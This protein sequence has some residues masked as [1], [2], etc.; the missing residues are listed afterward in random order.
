MKTITFQQML[1]GLKK[2]VAE[3][4]EDFVYPEE[5]KKPDETGMP[6]CQY[7]N[8]DGTP[9]CIAGVVL[10]DLLPELPLIEGNTVKMILDEAVE[11]GIVEFDSSLAVHLLWDAQVAQDEGATWGDA[12]ADATR[13]CESR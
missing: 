9:S 11:D 12:L 8:D 7:R 1:D 4:G 5:W 13:H 3:R 6:M 2:A 10:T